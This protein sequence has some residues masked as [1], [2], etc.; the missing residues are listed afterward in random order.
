MACPSALRQKGAWE[1][2]P[3]PEPGWLQPYHAHYRRDASRGTLLTG[4]TKPTLARSTFSRH[5][6]SMATSPSA[7][8]L[9]L[10]AL[11]AERMPMSHIYQ[12][13][14]LMELLGRHSPAPA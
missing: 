7:A 9:R 6:H 3:H 5:H 10:R 13:L 14:M 2:Q 11:I 1:A 12:P 8:F 4:H